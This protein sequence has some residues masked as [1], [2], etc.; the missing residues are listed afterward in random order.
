MG[1]LNDLYIQEI[2]VYGSIISECLRPNLGGG[3]RVSLIRVMAS[4]ELTRV[5]PDDAPRLV[6]LNST[7]T[8]FHRPALKVVTVD[9]YMQRDSPQLFQPHFA[10]TQAF[11]I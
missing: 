7:S 4:A 9:T 1:V 3:C 8:T 5:P 10:E 2:E 6:P 11:Y